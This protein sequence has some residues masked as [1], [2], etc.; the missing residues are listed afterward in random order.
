MILLLLACAGR[1]PPPDTWNVDDTQKVHQELIRAFLDVNDCDKALDSVTGARDHGLEGVQLDLL[2]A[3]ALL[4][5]GLPRDAITLLDNRYRNNSR[6]NALVCVAH[7]DLG[8]LD[9]AVTTCRLAVR[10]LPKDALR[11]DQA[12]AWQNL[13]FVLAASDEHADAVD[14]YQQALLLDPTYGRAR[15]NLAFSLVALGNDDEALN[16]FRVA[17]QEQYG[18]DPQLLEANAHYNLGL[19]QQT[20]GDEDQARQSYREALTTVPDHA[21]ALAALDDLSPNK[22]AP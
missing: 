2:H 11:S 10:E 7:A 22:E 4:C 15:N 3:E 6:R 1:T 21:L 5:K 18:N 8:E 16:T 12:K 9:D 19:A 17:L 13:G 20:R 14:A